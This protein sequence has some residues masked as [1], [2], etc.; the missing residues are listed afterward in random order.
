VVGKGLSS[1]TPIPIRTLCRDTHKRLGGDPFGLASEA[2]LHEYRTGRAE[3]VLSL[4][5]VIS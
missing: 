4:L 5:N 2:T 3:L 1:Y